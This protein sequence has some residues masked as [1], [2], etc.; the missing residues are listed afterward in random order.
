ML[1]LIENQ[2]SSLTA[3]SMTDTLTGLAN[4]R[5]FD[6]RMALDLPREHRGNRPLTLLVLDVDYFKRYN[7]RYGHPQGDVALKLLGAV[8][9]Q[10]CGR[11]TDLVA[12]IGGEEFAILLPETDAA[13]ALDIAGRIQTLLRE[14]NIA[15]ESSDAAP[16]MTVSIGIAQAHDESATALLQRADAALYQ[17]KA[18][19]RN[20]AC[21]SE[22]SPSVDK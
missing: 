4:R 13:A 8:L 14:R 12:R 21:C 16:W 11:A 6:A 20:R 10:A 3:L 2:M 5:A 15:H 9:R 18:Q 17:A 7:D 1:G 19:G 22:S